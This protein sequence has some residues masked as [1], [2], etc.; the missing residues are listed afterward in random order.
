MVVSIWIGIF[1][2]LTMARTSDIITII[3]QEM[4]EQ[5]VTIYRL[6]QLSGLTRRT[7]SATLRGLTNPT[8]E[9]IEAMMKPLGLSIEVVKKGSVK[10]PNHTD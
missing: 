8:L 5:A 4:Q 1:T 2:A 7:I 3:K 6:A 10:A 9:T